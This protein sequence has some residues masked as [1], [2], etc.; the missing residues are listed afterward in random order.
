MASN[1]HKYK[2][3][4]IGDARVGKTT[5]VK[6]VITNEFE[7]KYRST[8]GVEVH[9]LN[10]TLHGESG[11]HEVCFKIWDCA[12]KKIFRGLEEAYFIESDGCIV[13]YDT[14]NETTFHGDGNVSS[15]A[16]FKGV[17]NWIQDFKQIELDAK[18]V[19]VGTKTDQM[20]DFD[21]MHLVDLQEEEP[22][23][24]ECAISCV[25]D[26]YLEPFVLLARDLIGDYSLTL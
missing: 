1:S 3:C 19:V 2:I 12:G 14:T 7:E 11:T 4:M 25:Q 26:D 9:P 13:M 10:F 15:F 6:K 21:S 18:V 20:S 24:S 16:E 23:I 22:E 17:R 5:L 8:L